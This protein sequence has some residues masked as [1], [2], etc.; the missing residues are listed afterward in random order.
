MLALPVL[1]Q[2]EGLEG[3]DDVLSLDRGHLTDVFDR[4]VAAMLPQNLQ[5]NLRLSTF[6]F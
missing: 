2:V 5:Q 6:C 3:G 1:D 4:E